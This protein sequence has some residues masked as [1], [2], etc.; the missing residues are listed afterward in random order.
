MGAYIFILKE[1]RVAMRSVSQS[2]VNEIFQEALQL[3]PSLMI[4][5]RWQTKRVRRKLFKFDEVVIWS[6]TIYH[7]HPSYDGSPYQ[8]RV[9]QCACGDKTIVSAYLYGI[10]N[11]ALAQRNKQP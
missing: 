4:S 3:C 5:E 11:G 9:Q 2:E 8:A 7:E 1:D 6:Y 10:I